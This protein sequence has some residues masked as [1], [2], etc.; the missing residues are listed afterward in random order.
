MTMQ[1]YS[2][3]TASR[4][5][6]YAEME[7]LKHAMP[8]QVL[9]TF[10]VQK[11]HPLRKTDTVVFRRVRPFNS[12]VKSNPAD[13][14]SETP[15]ITPANFVTAE[16]TTPTPNTISYTDVT[17]TL[18]Q[19]AILFKFSS[20]A[21]LMYEDNIPDDMKKQTGETLGEVA[22]L[23]CYGAVKAGTSVLYANGSTRAGLNSIITLQKLQ[24]AARAIEANRGKYVNTKI[25]AGPNFG[26]APVEPSYCVFVHTDNVSD[27]R[28]LPGFT[29]RVEYGSA[30]KAVH[31]R[32]FG[33]VEDFRFIK[34]PLFEPFLAAG[35]TAS[36]YGMKSAGGSNCDVYPMIVMAEDAWG[37][38]SLK[39]NGYTGISP[40]IISSKTKNH[41]NPSGMFG[42]VGAD[43]WYAGVRLNENWMLRIEV[44]VTD[45]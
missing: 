17:A 16:G 4:N 43:F 40:T 31:E 11:Q 44:C 9:G 45:I 23:V 29:K 3:P 6:I 24:A 10:G 34:S 33:A 30:I 42:Y 22:E 8:I 27:I 35:A 25:A 26:T 5:L 36:G 15:N 21:E 12:T 7:M 2:S 1:T 20:K 39:G 32:E 19:Y 18:E 28:S 37:H 38:I 41:A 13:G 14:Y